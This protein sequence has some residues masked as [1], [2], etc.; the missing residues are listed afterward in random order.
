MKQQI[1]IKHPLPNQ[2]LEFQ[3]KPYVLHVAEEARLL[4]CH[5]HS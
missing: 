4:I 1:H 5:L 2:P 3:K